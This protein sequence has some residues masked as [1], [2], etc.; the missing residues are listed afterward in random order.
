VRKEGRR[1]E[2]LATDL[3]KRD[4]CYQAVRETVEKLGGIDILVNNIATQKPVENPDDLTDEQWLH[5]FDVNMHSY[6]RVTSEALKHMDEG[7]AIVNT[8]SVNGLRGNKKLIDYS[9]T[10]GA[11]NAWTYSMA[12]VLAERKIRINTVAPGPVW[13]P[14]IPSTLPKDHVEEFGGN[15]PLGRPA[16]PDELAPSYVFLAANQLS[17]YYTGEVIAA[18]GGETHPG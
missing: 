15:V 16:H 8:S 11:I 4:N 7:A 5:T 3:G 9:A 1:C 14:L 17:S 6:F 10:K 18:L 2:L 13:T 12:Q